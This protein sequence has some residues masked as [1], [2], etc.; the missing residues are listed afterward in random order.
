MSHLQVYNHNTK[1]TKIILLSVSD[2]LC[3]SVLHLIRHGF[4]R[5]IQT[6]FFSFQKT[7][8]QSTNYKKKLCY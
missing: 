8:F 3:I 4:A 1:Q 2:A 6:F 5:F 7:Q